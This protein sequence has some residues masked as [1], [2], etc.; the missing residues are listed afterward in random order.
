M[1]GVACKV[2]ILGK[3]KRWYL[4]DK[5]RAISVPAHAARPGPRVFCLVIGSK[6]LIDNPRRLC[7]SS[8]LWRASGVL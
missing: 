2:L 6:L 3:N 8:E 4:R 1:N 5:R 7:F